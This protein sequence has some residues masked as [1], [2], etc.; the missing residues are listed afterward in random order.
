[1]PL[2]LPRHLLMLALCWL[3]VAA[4]ADGSLSA[5]REQELETLLVAVTAAQFQIQLGDFLLQTR[6]TL[7]LLCCPLLLGVLLF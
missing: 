6:A 5:E 2:S 3:P 1:M 4:L 7:G